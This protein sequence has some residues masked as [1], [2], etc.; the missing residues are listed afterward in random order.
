MPCRFSRIH[1]K[2]AREQ[3]TADLPLSSPYSLPPSLSFSL[4][5]WRPQPDPNPDPDAGSL[6]E[7]LRILLICKIFIAFDWRA[8]S[9]TRKVFAQLDSGP[10][11]QISKQKNVAPKL[12]KEGKDI[13]TNS[14]NS[15]CVDQHKIAAS[16]RNLPTVERVG[17]RE[18]RAEG[19]LLTMA[20]QQAQLKLLPGSCCCCCCEAVLL[21]QRISCVVAASTIVCLA[22]S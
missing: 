3:S 15:C 4:S 18:G 11:R 10:K 5:R 22:I 17:E 14:K 19:L 2:T 7:F 6:C 12:T 16:S 8:I 1:T 9:S 13:K 20:K 21:L